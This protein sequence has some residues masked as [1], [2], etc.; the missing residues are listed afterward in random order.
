MDY[1]VQNDLDREYF[2]QDFKPVAGLL[3]R[4]RH[5]LKTGKPLET[6][7]L[8]FRGIWNFDPALSFTYITLFQEGL[9]PIRYGSRKKTMGLTLNRNIEK[10]RENKNFSSFDIK[11]PDKCRI[12]IEFVIDKKETNLDKLQG[13]KFD[14]YRFEPGIT[15]LELQDEKASYYYMPTDAIVQSQMGLRSALELLA[16]RSPIGKLTNKISERMRLLYGAS[17]FKLYLLKT[18]AFVT[19]Q[20]DCVP[21]YRGNIL[22]KGFSYETLLGQ[23]IKS[24]DWLVDNMYDDGR[25]LYY[26]DCKEDNF[27]D[28]EH[29]TR[30]ENNLYYNDLRHSGGTITLVRA[31]SQTK[32]QKYI[33]AAKKSLDF[34]VSITQEHITEGQKGYYT[35]YNK[36]AKLG[37]TGLA[38]IAFMQY[39]IVTGDK[40]YDEFIKGYVRHLLSRIYK[41]GEF[42]GYYIHPAYNN[43]KPLLKLDEKER[44]ETFSFYYPG[45]ALLGLALFSNHFDGDEKL[46]DE[47]RKKS[48]RALDWIVDDRPNFYKDLFTALPSDAWLMQAIEEWCSNP[49]FIKDNY[50]KFV[51]DDAKTMIAKTY[52]R[53][54]S[55]FIDFE[56]GYYY[57]WGDHYYPDGARSEGLVAAYYLAKKLG[58]TEFAKELLQ[59]CKNV[60]T[61]QFQLFNAPQMTYA[62]KNPKRSVN[63]IR[64]KST[65]Q[66]VRV[67]S[68]QHVACFFIRLYW[69]ENPCAK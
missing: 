47:V 53:D 9:T 49:E 2:S 17:N 14:E 68:I 45:E 51:F 44:R 69:A 8:N 43:G 1:K 42:L 61:C 64:F 58:N 15:G 52:T 46:V 30:P 4:I 63:G 33:E 26:Y 3:N 57:D 35:F 55:P 32:N 39:R 34:T 13:L 21:L 29:P 20:N 66:W 27:K 67:D 41:T 54:D 28:H 19:Y 37:G 48:K 11:N 6:T 25:F 7:N 10:L 38:L 24:C 12:M 59:A 60:A 36:K 31:Y 56:G 18:R 23:F 65:R 5:A 62:H 22:Y 40:S 50:L 16:K